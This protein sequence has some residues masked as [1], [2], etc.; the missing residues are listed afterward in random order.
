[1]V[2]TTSFIKALISAMACLVRVMWAHFSQVVTGCQPYYEIN[3]KYS[4][5]LFKI[6]CYGAESR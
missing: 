5:N 4:R 6:R 1:M 3:Y 2:I